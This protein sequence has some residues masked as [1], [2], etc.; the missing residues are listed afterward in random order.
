MLGKLCGMFC[1]VAVFGGSVFLFIA[2]C[3]LCA[4]SEVISGSFRVI[5]LSFQCL[6]SAVVSCACRRKN[7]S[8]HRC[9][10]STGGGGRRRIRSDSDGDESYW[11]GEQRIFSAL[12]T[13]VSTIYLILI[14]SSRNQ[15]FQLTLLSFVDHPMGHRQQLEIVIPLASVFFH[16]EM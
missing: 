4:I 13:F 2:G 9:S 15:R 8:G 11:L 10:G 7:S 1:R 3:V 12:L 14:H 5:R 16:F 6:R